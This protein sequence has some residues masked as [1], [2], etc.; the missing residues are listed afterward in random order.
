MSGRTEYSF[1]RERKRHGNHISLRALRVS[2]RAY[3]DRSNAWHRLGA[4]PLK[5]VRIPRDEYI[6]RIAKPGFADYNI[7]L[8]PGSS[9]SVA[10]TMMPQTAV[11]NG[12]MPVRGNSVTLGWPFGLAAQLRVDDFLVDRHEVTNAEYKKFVDA[13]GYDNPEFWTEPFV[14]DGR[15]IPWQQA[16]DGFRDA[17]GRRGPAS[18]E[19]GSYPQGKEQH[20]VAGVSW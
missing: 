16:I 9:T 3:R 2:Y 8:A 13:G 19:V 5:D 12:M 14:R 15:T 7:L 20:T 17:T 1:A 4:T 10:F 18:W 11:P 6:F